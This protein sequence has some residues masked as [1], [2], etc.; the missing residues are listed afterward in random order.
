MTGHP[1]LAHGVQER[2]K[3]EL[4]DCLPPEETHDWTFLHLAKPVELL[5]KPPPLELADL[6]HSYGLDSNLFLSLTP[7]AQ[8]R[9]LIKTVRVNI[10]EVK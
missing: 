1:L 9:I 10:Y 8:M 3:L 6:P 2:L 7:K 4:K 5:L